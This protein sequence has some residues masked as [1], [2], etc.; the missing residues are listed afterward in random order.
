M[1]PSRTGAPAAPDALRALLIAT[2]LHLSLGQ[3]GGVGFTQNPVCVQNNCINPAFPGL[4]DLAQLETVVWQCTENTAV[5]PYLDFCSGV[6]NYQPAL[7]S[8][9]ASTPINNLV[10]AQD[11]AAATMFF[12]HLSGLGYDAWDF[13]S[14]STTSNPCIKS[15]WRMVCFTYF[16][17]VQAGCQS[18]QQTPYYRPCKDTCHEY[19]STCNVEC[20]D[21]GL[22]CVFD[23]AALPPT[24]GA[25]M[26]QS[27]YADYTGPSAQCTGSALLSTGS[28]MS[29]GRGLRAP[30]MLLLAIFGV[31]MQA[32]FGAPSGTERSDRRAAPTGGLMRYALM[33][34]LAACCLCLQGCTA[35]VPHHSVAN[36]RNKP[37]YLVSYEFVPPGQ[38]AATA[39]LNSCSQSVP[40]TMQ[41][42]GHGYCKAFS[43][44]SVAEN[45]LS[46]CLC[47]RDW[48]DPECKTKRKSQV[49]A[50]VLS[51]FG[52]FLGIDYFYLGWYVWGA[53]K[54][55]TLGGLG[56]WWVLD[57]I[58]TGAGPVYAHDFRVAN[59]LPHWVFVLTVVTTFMVIGFVWALESYLT[60]RKAKRQDMMKLQQG[61]ESRNITNSEE[62]DGPRFRSQMGASQAGFN[63]QRAYS[64]YGATLPGRL[65]R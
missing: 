3:T 13:Q 43:K 7:P 54:L 42:N 64:G 6:V 4:N 11:D 19:V 30:L 50:F 12:Y 34:A 55:V 24:S 59:D 56:F 16:P 45:A 65:Y 28:S 38:N 47:D 32:D 39:T 5:A 31:H 18:G 51:L 53:V 33:G 63:P 1:F 23:N 21:E 8:P 40:K 36:W 60:F 61:E 15:V 35:E 41:C 10:K 14:P 46:F 29:A 17:K 37:D 57:I 44:T 25:V 26:A 9:N 49:T 48:A 22:Q 52:G 58:R 27:G 2:V 20:C 62:I